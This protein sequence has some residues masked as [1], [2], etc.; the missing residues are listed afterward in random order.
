MVPEMDSYPIGRS[1]PP[2]EKIFG[3][4]HPICIEY[5][6]GNGDWIVAQAAAYPQYNWVAVE[7]KFDRVQK[8]WSK[9]K[10][11]KRE[12]LFIMCAEALL[13]TGLYI[14]SGSVAKV[15][16]N[17]PDPWPKRRHSHHRLFQEP[18]KQQLYRILEPQG[19]VT[20][21]TDDVSYSTQLIRC[22]HDKQLFSSQIEAPYFREERGEYGNSYF[23]TL[24]RS[25]GKKIHYHSFQRI[26]HGA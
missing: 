20:V 5:C 3:N 17:F 7:R 24:W 26:A 16:V 8:I 13:V 23:D 12:N 22:L 10:N 9:G 21:V 11:G 18:F 19:T 1:L 2:W 6:S 4:R 15:Y 25:Q 14:A